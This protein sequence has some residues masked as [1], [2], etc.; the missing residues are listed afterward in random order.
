M[1]S[2][3]CASGREAVAW[4]EKNDADV[5]MLDIEMPDL[6]GISALPLLLQKKRDLAVI[7]VSTL[8]APQRRDQLART[9]TGRVRLYPQA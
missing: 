3:R 9:G 5:V 1:S 2:R 6:D 4:F 7:M 8:H